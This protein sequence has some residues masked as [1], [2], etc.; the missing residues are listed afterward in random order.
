M[1]RI[2]LRAHK[3]PFRVVSPRATFRKNLIGENVGNLLFSSASYKLLQTAGTEVEVGGIQG[4][5]A[6]AARINAHADHVV[7]PLANAF[8]P[9][10]TAALDRMSETIEALRVPVTILGVGAQLRLD[11][12]IE[13]LDAMKESVSR[14]VRAVLERSPSIGVRGEFTERYL[15]SLGFSDVEVIGCPSVF[16]RGPGLRVEKRVRALTAASRISL[17]LS[18]Y[19]P[20][21]GPIVERH[22]ERYPHLRYAAQHRDALGMLLSHRHRSKAHSTDQTVLPTHHA[23]PL[24]RDGRT[25]FFVD[26]EPWMRYLADFDFS[27]GTRIH[28][29]I[30]AL[31]A[32]TPAMVLA[33]DSRTLELVRYYDIPHRTMKQVRPDT[34]AA[35]LY[36][37]TDLTA[38]NAGLGERFD[39]FSAFLGA[40]G[41]HHV[42]EEG[43]DATRFD[44]RVAAV[45][46]PGD[47]GRKAPMRKLADRV[48]TSLQPRPET[49]RRPAAA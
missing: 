17:N 25:S 9:S 35:E 18:P 27:F 45:R 19:V 34:D 32:G 21:L 42:Y 38:F 39:R 12:R 33:H 15:K 2:L 16:L 48:V 10:Y 44:R 13:R 24:V 1:T 29:N 37:E 26:P 31:L 36:A 11:G 7:I 49:A 3:D 46:W 22:T 4:G 41:L 6:E 14:F 23:H 30:A 43:Q 40:H 8:R 20:G 28:G 47:V 5:R